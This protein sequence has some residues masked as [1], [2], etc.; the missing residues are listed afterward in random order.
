MQLTN[1]KR[2]S[3]RFRSSYL[4]MV[5][6]L[7]FF[8]KVQWNRKIEHD[9]ESQK[10]KNNQICTQKKKKKKK[11][12]KISKFNCDYLNQIIKLYR[13]CNNENVKVKNNSITSCVIMIKTIKLVS[14]LINMLK[15]TSH[16]EGC[17]NMNIIACL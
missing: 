7:F 2:W 16:R 11:K 1:Q 14:A 12:P 15:G 4:C 8:F 10:L 5:D 3:K 9:F 6:N 13:K 17:S